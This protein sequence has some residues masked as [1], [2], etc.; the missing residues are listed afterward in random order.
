MKTHTVKSNAKRAARKLAETLATRFGRQVAEAGEPS[1]REGEWMGTLR[2]LDVEALAAARELGAGI[3]DVLAEEACE[4]EPSH[5]EDLVGDDPAPV[6]VV[7]MDV[8]AD[9]VVTSA[10]LPEPRQAPGRMNRA[11]AAAVAAEPATRST[12]DEVRARREAN[13]ERRLERAREESKQAARA[14]VAGTG[15]KRD[16][17]KRDKLIELVS[18]EGGATSAELCEALGWQPHTVRGFI[19]GTLRKAGHDIRLEGARG[20]SRYKLHKPQGEAA[21]EGGE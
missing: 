14:K 18:R 2:V 4:P 16:G 3:V 5:I 10:L 20:A 15:K 7:G 17:A 19:A 9:R 1:A 6:E 13:R 21:S 12:P 8:Q 11:A